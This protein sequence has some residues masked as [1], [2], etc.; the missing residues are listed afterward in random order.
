MAETQFASLNGAA[1]YAATLDNDTFDLDFTPNPNA[2]ARRSISIFSRRGS[3][4]PEPKPPFIAQAAMAKNPVKGLKREMTE[5]QKSWLGRR[6]SHCGSSSPVQAPASPKKPKGTILN[7]VP[8]SKTIKMTA[9]EE[10]MASSPNEEIL[11]ALSEHSPTQSALTARSHQP[12]QPSPTQQ[13]NSFWNGPSAPVSQRTQSQKKGDTNSRIGLWV[14][15]V[16]QWDEHLPARSSVHNQH[17]EWVEEA[18]QEVT[19]FTPL[20]PGAAPVNVHPALR[21][22]RPSLS[23]LI[24][25]GSERKANTLALSTITQPKPQRPVVS[26]APA[27]IIS[28]FNIATPAITIT[29][30]AEEHDV[31]PLESIQQ[32]PPP[33]PEHSHLEIASADT[34]RPK[35]SR[36]S[37]SSAA[38]Y[39]TEHDETFSTYSK[40]S[41]ATSMES[42]HI[43]IPEKSKKRLSGRALTSSPKPAPTPTP[44]PAPTQ[45]APVQQAAD[46]NKPL[47]PNP[48]P[49]PPRLAPAV[50]LGRRVKSSS[51]V[52][53]TP[54]VR[55][56]LLLQR[57]LSMVSPRSFSAVDLRDAALRRSSMYEHEEISEPDLS[58]SGQSDTD[59]DGEI[60]PST[61]TL[62]QAEDELNAQLSRW[63]DD[64]HEEAKAPAKEVREQ[65]TEPEVALGKSTSIRRSDSVRSV[66]H[67][68][69]RAPTVPRRS[70]KRDWRAARMRSVIPYAAPVRRSSESRLQ[71]Q[72]KELRDQDAATNS[73]VRRAASAAQ[74]STS[75]TLVQQLTQ[76]ASTAEVETKTLPR[77]VIDDGL[78]VVQ[79]PT[80][81]TADGEVVSPTALAAASA[82]DVLL[83]IL[84]NLCTL[85]DLFSTAQINKGMYRVYKE[86]EM[87]LVRTVSLN[88]SPAAWEFR[89][90]CPPD[91][92]LSDSSSKA[93]SQLEHSPQTYMRCHRRDS[94]VVRSL[95][96]LILAQCQ[97]IIRPET[98]SALSNARHSSAQRFD[99]AFWRIWCFCKIFGCEKG[100]EDDVTGQLDWLKGGL[101]ANNQGC[102]ATVNTNLEF[103][104]SSVL[105]NA[106]DH[107]AKGNPGGLSAQQLYD[108]T[109][110]WG[111][112][113]ALLQGYQGRV[114]QAR[115]AGVFDSCTDVAEGD[116]EKEELMLE[117]WIHHLLTLGPT[118][119]LEMAECATDDSSAGF[120]LAKLN[121]WTRW[122]PPS[123]TGSR[124]TFLKEPVARLYEERVAAAGYAIEHPSERERKET[125]RKRVASLAAEIRLKRQTS[126]YKR[127]PYIDM[128]LERSMS[129]MSR[130]NSTLSS[131]SRSSH[132]GMVSPLATSSPHYSYGSTATPVSA[133]PNFSHPYAHFHEPAAAAS[134]WSHGRKISPIIEERVVSFNRLSLQN[135]LAGEA[136][137]TSDRAVKLGMR[138]GLHGRASKGGTSYDRYGGRFESRSGCGSA[139]EAEGVKVYESPIVEF[140]ALIRLR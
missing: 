139:V 87:H 81:I 109:E 131:S 71:T 13:K 123:F 125:S 95:K 118:V 11:S 129:G 105:L 48:H 78:I 92:N 59:S 70:R 47:P 64:G 2:I 140:G 14:N 134:P 74:L 132:R 133:M 77:I 55:P 49:L 113:S 33:E 19:H 65:T 53:S 122:T 136:D 51:S 42:L 7:A 26:V 40:R 67:P 4:T 17:N 5:K 119:V 57:P 137:N 23:V 93:S 54:T 16:A 18:M 21:G 58:G 130:R 84:A 99:N 68:P 72:R 8:Q 62:S 127:S 60:E 115:D 108:M 24:P 107:F 120:A 61:P 80:I 6:R 101:L 75:Y 36:E 38:S 114:D 31:S 112:L 35:P 85:D 96:A 44:A 9:L 103:D 97:G 135:P 34:L 82:E 121:G 52:R 10:E 50:P 22:I 128:S 94:A 104:M 138:D 20:H 12:S 73:I 39:L 126:S 124:S 30:E 106:P 29:G 3:E 76:T 28:R 91:R 88:Q 116:V 100:R 56:G 90:W 79:G 46:L 37:S 25:H 43:P 15:G 1:A 63:V 83:H 32:T 110:I 111:C 27:S 102:V 41:S 86:N 69:E 45:E 89:E 66:M 117:E 98:A